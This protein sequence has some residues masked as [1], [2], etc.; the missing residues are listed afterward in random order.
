MAPVRV[1][2][3]RAAE[4]ESVLDD[5]R[6]QNEAAA[7]VIIVGMAVVLSTFFGFV[8][9][10]NYADPGEEVP[11]VV[12]GFEYDADDRELTITHRSG[13]AFPA[14]EV[15]V[16]SRNRSGSETRR[17]GDAGRVRAGDSITVRD[18]PADA[19]VLVVWDRGSADRS[20]V[21]GRWEG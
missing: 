12:F 7:M 15:Y 16:V 5:E 14:E 13:D 6:G 17:W 8:V 11:Y 3:T 4:P 1:L 20:Y 19:T 9:F 10:Q 2:L 21:V 18:V